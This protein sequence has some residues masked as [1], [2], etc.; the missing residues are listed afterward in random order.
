[1]ASIAR[2]ARRMAGGAS[3][4]AKPVADS[5]QNLQA[6]L[7]L[8][9][10]NVAEAT[11]YGFNPITRER[12]KLE[13]IY[14]GTWIGGVAVDAVAEDMTR[15]GIDIDSTMEPDDSAR[16]ISA[17][18]KMQIWQE[19]GDAIRWSRLYGGAG[20][21]VLIDGQDTATPLRLDTVSKGQ[22]KGLYTVDRYMV[23]PSMNDIVTDPGP[24][25]GKPATYKIVTVGTPLDGK[26]VH[27]SRF[28]RFEGPRLP[29]YQRIA[30]MGWGMSIVERLYDRL[31]AFDSA[32]QGAAQL[33]FK[34]HLRTMKKKGLTNILGAGGKALE[35]LA[36]DIEAIRRF[37]TSE[38]MTVVDAE[39]DIQYATYTFS[40]LS[41]MIIQFGQQISGALQIP[42]VRLF[43]QSPVGMNATGDSDLRTY[44]DG[45][46]SQ[47]E[48][49]LRG[50]MTTV[51]ELT[52]R[53]ELGAPLPPGSNFDF[54][55]LWQMSEKEKG[56]VAASLAGAVVGAFEAGVISKSVALRELR[57]S[58]ET[59]GV[60]SNITDEMI[61]DAADDPPKP[62]EMEAGAPN[63][64]PSPK[65][66]PVL[67]PTDA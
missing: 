56:D 58:S 38:G 4:T 18:E 34:A 17:F 60:F 21:V 55:S 45:V 41:D 37:Q 23:T 52:S 15:A 65:N 62:S 30:E 8:G 47:Q 2:Q 13:M 57:E 42:L 63:A 32:T 44:Y 64:E 20:A 40:G 50:P 49:K 24:S 16:I 28:I 25:Y 29:F 14:R 31:V 67:P 27:H 36:R 7:G 1:M 46:K 48:A 12:H 59:T 61:E 53:S 9:S 54:V 22:F 11:S 19:L 43:G 33:V 5:M 6:R 39:D 10:G 26:T 51:L 3:A 35:A 66:V